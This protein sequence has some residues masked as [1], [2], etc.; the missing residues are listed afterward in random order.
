[1]Y[2]VLEP[3]GYLVL[4]I[5]KEQPMQNGVLQ[6]GKTMEVLGSRKF[7][8]QSVLDIDLQKASVRGNIPTEHI[9]FFKK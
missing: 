1:M 8:V 6:L 2:E 9:I 4:I 3:D 7:N 5:G